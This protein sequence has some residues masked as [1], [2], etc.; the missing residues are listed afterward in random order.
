MTETV[1]SPKALKAKKRELELVKLTLEVREAKATAAKAEHE[2]F[3]LRLERESSERREKRRVARESLDAAYD[4]GAVITDATVDI[5]NG[6]L[7]ERVLVAPRQPVTVTLYSPGG[8]VFAGFAMMDAM[9][10]AQEAG[11]EITMKIT[12]YG[13]SMAGIILQAATTRLI[14]KDSYLMLHEVSTGMFGGFKLSELADEKD[15]LDRLSRQSMEWFAKRSNG[16]W[17][18]DDLIKKIRK[19]DWWLSADEALEAGFVD[20]VY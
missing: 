19:L 3:D 11:T 6:W 20:G 12:G 1:E 10:E 14:G 7:R 13:A 2:E 17:T 8:S 16:K 5:F 18:T 15:F 4:F 9:R